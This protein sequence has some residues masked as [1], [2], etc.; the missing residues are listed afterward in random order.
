VSKKTAILCDFDGTIA[1]RDV[2]HH[3]FGTFIADKEGWNSLL[4][5]W[6]LGLISSRECLEQEFEWL[7]ADRDDLDEFIS[8]EKIDQYFT[9]F[10]DFCNKRAIELL[11][12]SDGL[13]YYIERILIDSGLGHLDYRANR[14]VIGNGDLSRIEFPYYNTLECTRCGNCKRYHLEKLKAEGFFVIYIGNGLSDRCPVEH[15][16]LVFAKG[17]LLK[18]CAQEKIACVPFSNFRDIER[19]LTGRF[20]L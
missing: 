13:D 2:G 12:V 4:S 18:H 3:L 8:N 15:A 7:D 17:E 11:I 14:L 20:L 16:G 9:D 6:K 1:R 10:V 19:E 5:R